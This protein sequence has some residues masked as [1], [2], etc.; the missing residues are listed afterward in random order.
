[1]T[2][3]SPV[4]SPTLVVEG[5]LVVGPSGRVRADVVCRDGR[6]AALVEP[7]GAGAADERV[8]AG[9]CL[10]LPGGVDPHS[11][12]MAD[13]R[14]ATRAA[15]LGGTTTVLS[16]TNP[17]PGEGALACLQRRRSELA[18]HPPAADVGLH[19][20]L[21][22]PDRVEPAELA[23]LVKEGVSGLK[24]FLA[25]PELGIMWSTRGLFELLSAAAP[26]GQV[27]QVHCEEGDVIDGLV[28]RALEAGR[29]GPDV[30]A[31]T[32]PA[33]TEASAVARVLQV[34]AIAGARCYL[35]HL[36]AA[37]SLEQVRTARAAGS[38]A[39]WA[40]VC[41]HHLVFDHGCYARPDA[42]RFL[43]AP[44]LRS[45][46]DAEAL[47]AALADGSLDTVG[48]DHS[49]ARSQTIGELSP[50][51]TGYSYGIAGVGAR[52]PVLLSHGLARRVPVERL[53]ALS[54]TNAAAAFGHLGRKGLVAPGHDAD[55][56]VYD[57]E[58]DLELTTTTFDDGTG[59]SVYAG[60][61][62]SGRIRH[63]LRGG[64]VVVSEGGFV[65]SDDGGSYLASS[66]DS[67][68]GA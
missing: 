46:G 49:Q 10:V 14:A 66:R 62:L 7:G 38:P 31:A 58:G 53:V 61:Q 28:A 26:L 60:G 22:E 63:V 65:G 32:R 51:G 19:A 48:S 54:S 40:E 18:A 34:A 50:D 59:D 42:E 45:A 17:E 13:P 24:I 67:A 21:Y 68:P 30:F 4:P 11:H 3:A 57:P 43:V 20:M 36:S 1:M 5:G 15:V 41:T 39:L 27:V 44:P 33:G 6:I 8:D 23:A 37:A 55:I 64:E 9:G 2:P 16:F 56:V 52:L 47:W 29:T 25:Y 35:T 12:V